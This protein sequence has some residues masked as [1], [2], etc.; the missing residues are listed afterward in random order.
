M[1]MCMLISCHRGI[2]EVKMSLPRAQAFASFF[3][4]TTV[5]WLGKEN[6]ILTSGPFC[7][8]LSMITAVTGNVEQSKPDSHFDS[9]IDHI[10]YAY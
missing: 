2:A 7:Q 1:K 10:F 5:L 8:S 3:K 9:Q 4:C 6:L